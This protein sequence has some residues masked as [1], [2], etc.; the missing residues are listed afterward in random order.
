MTK[1]YTITYTVPEDTFMRGC[2]QLWA[3]RAL[4]RTGNIVVG[5]VLLAFAVFLLWQGVPGPWALIMLAAAVALLAMDAARDRLWR[6]HYR[7]LTKYTAL[8][9]LSFADAGIDMQSA[10]AST[11][12]EWSTFKHYVFTRDFL[13][14]VID[15]RQFS[16]IPLTAFDTP[17]T[18]AGVE[19]LLA[20]HLK[21]LRGR[22]L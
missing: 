1:T 15:Q 21:L 19:A 16:V 4:G 12:L 2:Y 9:R 18:R 17:A 3:H 10:E 6:R 14:L 11:R 5:A 20:K 13:F 7:G 8:I 22:L